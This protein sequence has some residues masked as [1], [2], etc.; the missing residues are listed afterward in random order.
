MPNLNTFQ[1][2]VSLAK[3]GSKLR[4]VTASLSIIFII[5]FSIQMIFLSQFGIESW[6]G[7]FLLSLET[8]SISS[9]LLSFVS[10]GSPI[11]LIVNTLVFLTFSGVEERIPSPIYLA[12]FLGGSIIGSIAQL[13]VASYSGTTMNLLGASAGIFAVI[14]LYA[15]Y[16]PNRKVYIL[17][18]IPA[19]IQAAVGALF[20]GTI[21]LV[22]VGGVGV[23][24]IG[25]MAHLGGLLS[26]VGVGYFARKYWPPEY[27]DE[28]CPSCK[29]E[30]MLESAEDTFI[31]R[32]C[33]HK[34]S[35]YQADAYR[36]SK[37]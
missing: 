25:H 23:G 26:G 13:G 7:I 35:E 27:V 9:M 5:V 4:P 1:K 28:S 19:N 2:I 22:S 11:H 3:M 36:R 21:A 8:F 33:G 18:F 30:N 6:K 31:C 34:L 10:H 29:S 32:Q 24:S 12:T 16:Y 37:R 15:L 20:A 14:G 17:F